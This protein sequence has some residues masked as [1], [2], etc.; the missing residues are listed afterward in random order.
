MSNDNKHLDLWNRIVT[1]D[2]KF[3]KGG[4]VGGQQ[5]TMV[6]AQHKKMLIT[7]EFGPYGI[8]WGIVA[9]SEVYER[10]HYD[11]STCILQYTATAFYVYEGVRAELP[12]SSAIKEA[13]I[14]SGGK[15]YLKI[16][17]EAVKKVKT[18]SLTKAFTDVGFCADIHM[19]LFD[20]QDYVEGVKVSAQIKQEDDSEAA[21]KTAYAAMGEYCKKEID[22]VKDLSPVASRL[23]ARDRIIQKVSIR[24]KAAKLN[25]EKFIMRINQLIPNEEPTNES[26]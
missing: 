10:I 22:A 16:D 21:H 26:K 2:P 23:R 18:D 17:D 1:T 12:L 5:R 7:S 6:D 24:C 4:K 9:G 25:P 3:V 13:Y 11:D 19:G 14:T 20:D 15:G 8:G